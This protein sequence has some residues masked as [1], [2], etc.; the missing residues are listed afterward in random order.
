MKEAEFIME[1]KS[2]RKRGPY[3]KKDLDNSVLIPNKI[4]K[5][6]DEELLAIRPTIST[7]NVPS[8]VESINVSFC[9]AFIL[10]SARYTLGLKKEV[11]FQLHDQP[12]HFTPDQ[13]KYCD[14]NN[15]F[16]CEQFPHCRRALVWY[17]G[18]C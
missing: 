6:Y 17:P 3:G 8:A 16:I 13:K 9:V 2:G 4:R 18:I 12:Y 1:N 11:C 15:I 7:I 10:L 14:F 5:E